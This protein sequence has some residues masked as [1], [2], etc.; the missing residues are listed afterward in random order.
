MSLNGQAQAPTGNAGGGQ[1][2]GAQYVMQQFNF[3]YQLPGGAYWVAG[4]FS[5]TLAQSTSRY[6]LAC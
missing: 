3:Q 5:G 2:A 1:S 6:F 4:D